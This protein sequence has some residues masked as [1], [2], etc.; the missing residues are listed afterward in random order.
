MDI[1]ILECR[2][3]AP[4]VP[5]SANISRIVKDYEIDIELGD[6]RIACING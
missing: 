2:K 6:G 1:N 4:P 3:F 5:C